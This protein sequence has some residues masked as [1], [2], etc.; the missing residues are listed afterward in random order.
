M[1][2]LLTKENSVC[3]VI[4]GK[5]DTNIFFVSIF[6][7]NQPLTLQVDV[8]ECPDV[9]KYCWIRSDIRSL[10]MILLPL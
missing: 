4:W 9:H 2:I 1:G 5:W 8:V 6:G 7:M 3:V 10:V